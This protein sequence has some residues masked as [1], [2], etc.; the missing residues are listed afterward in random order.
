MV[1]GYRE[2]GWIAQLPDSWGSKVIAGVVYDL[3]HL[4]PFDMKVTPKA[5]GSPTFSVRVSFGCHTFTRDLLPT[6]KPDLFFRDGTEK[7]AFCTIRHGLS[8]GLPAMIQNAAGGR[9]FFSERREFLV[10]DAEAQGGPYVAFFNMERARNK[11]HDAAMFVTSAHCRPGL[12]KRLPAV[13][14]AT[15]VA[16]AAVGRK[17]R[18]PD[19]TTQAY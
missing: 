7:R 18:R 2:L 1:A 3:S 4:D 9:A 16:A 6:D 8:A 11:S 13:T 17:I 14:F 12:P 19:R 5:E 15:L 10:L